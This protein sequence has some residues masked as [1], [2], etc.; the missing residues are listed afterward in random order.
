MDWE[1][2]S[3]KV[4]HQKRNIPAAMGIICY[5][6]EEFE[7]K[8]KQISIVQRVVKEEIEIL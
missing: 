3:A 6:P 5:T 1:E 8:K 4:S 7:K 2:R